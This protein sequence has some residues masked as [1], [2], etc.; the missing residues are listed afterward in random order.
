[1]VRLVRARCRDIKSV[2]DEAAVIRQIKTYL[3]PD[4]DDALLADRACATRPRS[5]SSSANDDA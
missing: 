3:A 1:M 5:S 4:V 2:I